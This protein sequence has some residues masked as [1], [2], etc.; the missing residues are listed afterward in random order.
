MRQLGALNLHEVVKRGDSGGPTAVGFLDRQEQRVAAESVRDSLGNIIN[1]LGS[2]PES[3]RADTNGPFPRLVANAQRMRGEFDQGRSLLEEQVNAFR[4]MVERTVDSYLRSMEREQQGR[5]RLAKRAD[6]LL[7]STLLY[8]HLT[9]SHHDEL[10]ELRQRLT[11]K[12]SVRQVTP[13]DLEFLEKRLTDIKASVVE[14]LARQTMRPALAEAVTR[15]VSEMGYEV[16]QEF[17]E[18]DQEELSP[19]TFAIP[20]GERLRVVVDP[21]GRLRFQVYHE[22]SAAVNGPITDQEV[23][24]LREQEARW[25]T[26]LQQLIRRLVEEGFGCQVLLEQKIRRDAIPVVVLD[27]EWEEAEENTTKRRRAQHK[28]KLARKRPI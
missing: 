17:P 25:C 5:E 3:L 21:L 19:A 8:G 2:L 1:I 6:S 14:E 9:T 12:L 23:A 11:K 18:A 16:L 27:T 20:G 7:E 26:D 28:Q 22:R 15:H 13:G 4:Q 10:A 24:F